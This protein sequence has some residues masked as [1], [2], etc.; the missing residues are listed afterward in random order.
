MKLEDQVC[1]LELAKRLKELGVKQES[2]FYWINDEI[3]IHREHAYSTID[4]NL[5]GWSS[6]GCG[7][8]SRG[9]NDLESWS[10]FTV[11]ELVEMLPATVGNP[12][13]EMCKMVGDNYGIEYICS[14]HFT[15]DKTFANACAKML[16]HLIEQGHVKV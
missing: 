14:D 4:P 2:I 12:H 1:S 10:A 11:A 7:C 3:L 8:C 15:E 16:I 13:L 6:S 9:E 5:T